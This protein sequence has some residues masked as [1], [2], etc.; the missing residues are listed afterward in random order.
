MKRL[1]ISLIALV[2]CCTT[3]S[4]QPTRRQLIKKINAVYEYIED[5]YVEDRPLEP[6]VEE[7]IRATLR[8]LDP[9]SQYL[10]KEEMEAASRNLTGEFAGIGINHLIHNDTLVVRAT[11]ENSPA[12]KA[13]ILPNDRIVAVDEES[14]VGYDIK[15][16]TSRIAGK[17][18]SRLTLSI[19]RRGES[20][21]ITLELRRE[22]I[23]QSPIVALRR[24]SIG[25]IAISSFT[26][27]L[28]SDFNLAYNSLGEVKALVIDLRDNGGGYLSAAIDLTSMFLSRGDVVVITEDRKRE[29]TYN[30]RRNGSLRDMPLV[31]V[32]DESTASSSEIFAGAIQDHDRGLI[33][34]RTSFGKGLIQKNIEY[35]DG[36]GFRITTARYKTPSGRPIQRPYVAGKRSAYLRDSMRFMHPDSIERAD[37]LHFKTLKLGRKVYGG[38]GITP[39]IYIGR[40]TIKLSN[41]VLSSLS[42]AVV[43]HSIVEY[44]DMVDIATIREEYPTMESFNDGYALSSEL[45]NILYRNAGY[46]REDI[47][48]AD[49]R[50][51]ETMLYALLAEQLYGIEARYYINISRIDYTAQQ[52]IAVA[53]ESIENGVI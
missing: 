4:A 49:Y 32:I 53:E 51:I 29:R 27:S 11:F 26:K 31:V 28:A 23:H 25:Y 1:L 20:A 50:Y 21:P 16:A 43:E 12:M 13:G 38:G 47:T 5:L 35:K 18:G 14:I 10:T 44:R 8:S 33:V 7:A 52:A 41:N 46:G 36:S 39:D 22:N 42:K 19:V 34:G 40:D 2:I 30:S 15:T 9:H 17:A 45:W 48:E 24:D 6:L 37:S 3:L